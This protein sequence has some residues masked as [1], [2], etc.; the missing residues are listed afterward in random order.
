M[1]SFGQLLNYGEKVICILFI[2]FVYLHIKLRWLI[3]AKQTLLHT[4][5]RAV[6]PEGKLLFFVLA[7]FYLE[8]STFITRY[9]EL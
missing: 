3:S 1:I 9:F 5:G 2:R 8:I 6:G 4:Y 7:T